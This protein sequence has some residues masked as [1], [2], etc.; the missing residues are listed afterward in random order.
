LLCIRHSI[1][2]VEGTVLRHCQFLMFL[3]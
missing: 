3:C 1:P 2:G